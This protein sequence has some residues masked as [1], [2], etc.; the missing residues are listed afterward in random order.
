M[1]FI[2][3]LTLLSRR[4]RGLPPNGLGV[5]RFYRLLLRDLPDMASRIGKTGRT[6]APWAIQGAVHAA[7]LRSTRPD[8][9]AE[10]LGAMIPGASGADREFLFQQVRTA[11]GAKALAWMRKFATGS[12]E[13][14][15]DA[16]TKTLGEWLSADAGP[17]LLE[18]A[19]GKGKFANRALAGYIRLFRQFELP[20]AERV[21]MAA[22]ALKVMEQG[23]AAGVL[24]TG[25]KVAEQQRFKDKVAKLV[26]EDRATL[27]KDL[28]NAK[29]ASDGT[30]MFNYGFNMVY[31]G[32][33]ER[34][35]AQMEQGLAKG[36]ALLRE[37]T[38][39]DAPGEMF[40]A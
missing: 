18:V 34:G 26:A 23:Y 24:G 7:I 16:A 20:E 33:T 1:I 40:W 10:T 35:V 3:K 6:D 14:L 19:R 31:L 27:E 17:V 32:L 25:D 9:C 11:G 39:F 12:S 28:T 13:A 21:A 36:I 38:M 30:A 2:L 8:V 4:S 22:E 37:V 5:S 15:Q 29:K